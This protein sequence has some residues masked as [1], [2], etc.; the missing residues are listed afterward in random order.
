MERAAYWH[1]GDARCIIA[2]V[3]LLLLI[4]VVL[5]SAF[6][7][8]GNIFISREFQGD[9]LDKESAMADSVAETVGT[10]RFGF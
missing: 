3:G 6:F 9:K 5:V 1:P 10:R 4:L 8:N 7:R 2:I